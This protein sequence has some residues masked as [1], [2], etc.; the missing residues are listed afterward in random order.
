M[1]GY[2]SF[3]IVSDVGAGFPDLDELEFED[4]P[5]DDPAPPDA[6]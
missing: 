2:E 6:A 3:D 5:D 4:E 1:A